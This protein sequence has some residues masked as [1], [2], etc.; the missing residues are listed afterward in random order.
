MLDW[1]EGD[2][3]VIPAELVGDEIT[4]QIRI[5]DDGDGSAEEDAPFA[6]AVFRKI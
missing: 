2:E 1:G 5:W 6:D 4:L 3:E